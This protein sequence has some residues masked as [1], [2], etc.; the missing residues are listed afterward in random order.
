M[1]G[2]MRKW[3]FLR[4]GWAACVNCWACAVHKQ[5]RSFFQRRTGAELRDQ[6]RTLT[7]SFPLTRPLHPRASPIEPTSNR[8]HR[9][10]CDIASP[11]A[12]GGTASAGLADLPF[13]EI[14][15]PDMGKTL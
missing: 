10:A 6:A 14:G 1:V 4:Q 5:P 12:V 11:L 2:A 7:L 15:T 8:V 3:R 13:N 9:C